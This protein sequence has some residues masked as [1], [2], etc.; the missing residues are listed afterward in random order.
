MLSSSYSQFTHLCVGYFDFS[1]E[2]INSSTFLSTSV[3]MSAVLALV[4]MAISLRRA[5]LAI[6]SRYITHYITYH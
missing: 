4:S 6:C 5:S 1:A 2:I 3:T